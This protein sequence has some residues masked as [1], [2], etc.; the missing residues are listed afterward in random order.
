LTSFGIEHVDFEGILQR[1]EG[2]EVAGSTANHEDSVCSDQEPEIRS[3]RRPLTQRRHSM[4]LL[5]EVELPHVVVPESCMRI[6]SLLLPESIG[7][8]HVPLVGVLLLAPPKM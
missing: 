5:D 3:G 8:T 6:K 7:V 1:L 4:E 2:I